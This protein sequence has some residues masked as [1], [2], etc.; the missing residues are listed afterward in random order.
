M[1]RIY[2][3]LFGGIE[4]NVGMWLASLDHVSAVYAV[5]KVIAK[6]KHI[7]AKG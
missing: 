4:K 2:P 5:R 7:Y 6:A 3:N 1:P